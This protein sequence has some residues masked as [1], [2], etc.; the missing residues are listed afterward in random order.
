MR[1]N[2]LKAAEDLRASSDRKRGVGGELLGA[3]DVDRNGQFGKGARRTRNRDHQGI[4]HLGL[5]QVG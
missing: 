1:R 5:N 4:E 2:R 3:K